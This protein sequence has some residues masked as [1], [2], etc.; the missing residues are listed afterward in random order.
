MAWK[1]LT[2]GT[3]WN[4]TDADLDTKLQ[5]WGG[6]PTFF[7]TGDGHEKPPFQWITRC[8]RLR[9][10]F[11]KLVESDK[12]CVHVEELQDKVNRESVPPLLWPLL[13]KN[14]IFG[15]ELEIFRY[16]GAVIDAYYEHAPGL[17]RSEYLETKQ[18]M[19]S[20]RNVQRT[21]MLLVIESVHRNIREAD[22]RLRDIYRAEELRGK[23][24]VHEKYLNYYRVPSSK[25]SGQSSLQPSE[26]PNDSYVDFLQNYKV[27]GL[28]ARLTAGVH[29]AIGK[30]ILDVV[31]NYKGRTHLICCGAEHLTVKDRPLNNYVFLPQRTTGVVD[32]YQG[33]TP[34]L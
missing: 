29:L 4:L 5:L 10:H 14:R 9:E 26:K 13:G 24:E 7:M 12:L 15:W 17:S 6:M 8:K 3:L 16:V 19:R 25:T 27:A 30:K 28:D 20:N 22:N 23:L 21:Q 1:T 18:G 34:R 32:S 33:P 2:P 31:R 11:K